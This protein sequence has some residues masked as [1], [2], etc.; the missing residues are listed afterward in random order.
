MNKTIY[1]SLAILVLNFCLGF[2]LSSS[3][4]N[5]IATGKLKTA[6]A[7]WWGTNSSDATEILQKAINSK[8]SKIIIGKKGTPWLTRPLELRSDLEIVIEKDA[9]LKAKPGEFKH[10]NDCLLN[11][12]GC[13]NIIIRGPGSLVMNKKDYQNLKNYK[14]SEWRHTINLK[15]CENVLIENLKII[16]SGG[17]GIYI[18]SRPHL[19]YWKGTKHYG[20]E[21]AK[22][23]N[24]CKNIKIKNCFIDDHHRQGISVISAENLTISNCQL[25]NTN[26]TSPMAGIDFEPNNG[27]QRLV[28]CLLENCTMQGNKSYGFLAYVKIQDTSEPISITVKDCTIKGG[29]KGILLGKPVAKRKIS[30]PA[31]GFIKF[32]NCRIENTGDAGIELKDFYSKGF[33][34]VFEN[35]K[36][37]NTAVKQ[38]GRSPIML[39]LSPGTVQNIGAAEFKNTSVSDSKKRP[40]MQLSN[41]AGKPF[42]EKISGTVV[43]NGKETD[44]ADYV[45]KHGMDKPNLSKIADVNLGSLLPAGGYELKKRRQSQPRLIMRGKTAFL[46]AANKGQQVEFKLLFSRVSRRFKLN[47]MKIKALSPSGKMI[48]LPEA[49]CMEQTNNYSFTAQETG[50]YAINCNPRGNKLS[51]KDSKVPYSIMLPTKGYLALYRP[52]GRVYFGIPAGISEFTVEI[53]G[54]GSE[55]VNAAVYIGKKRIASANSISAPR[56]FKVNC[57]PGKKLRYGSIVFDK[58]VEDAMLKIPVPLLPVIAADKPELMIAN[59]NPTP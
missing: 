43:Y 28:N 39:H 35:C 18:G 42:A 23:P 48:N 25:N 11:A 45:K 36:L 6:R 58:A 21:Y 53:G 40:L 3:P 29:G 8:A 4:L 31:N 12:V 16:G 34:A 32:I 13:K 44:M 19:K 47:P 49:K 59:E 56:K 38:P 14:H 2:T 51:I 46:L 52:Q 26:G 50:V 24:Y 30:N 55:T 10:L 7:E 27:E 15:S 37:V 33:K 9:V 5:K 17:D 20:K 41:L 54:Q 22:L 57:T 1:T